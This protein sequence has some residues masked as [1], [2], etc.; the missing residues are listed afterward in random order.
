[1]NVVSIGRAKPP[2]ANYLKSEEERTRR[3][4]NLANCSVH[5]VIGIALIIPSP[6]VASHHHRFLS[7]GKRA[8]WGRGLECRGVHCPPKVGYAFYGIKFVTLILRWNITNEENIS[9]SQ[10]VKRWTRKPDNTRHPA[11]RDSLP[12]FRSFPRQ[13]QKPLASLIPCRRS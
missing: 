3:R 11:R 6:A 9:F 1:M 2:T 10:Y 4:R 13:Q 7:Y 12:K 8:N 5:F